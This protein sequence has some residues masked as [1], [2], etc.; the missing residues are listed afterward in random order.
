[1]KNPERFVIRDAWISNE[2]RATLFQRAAVVVLP[3]VSATQSG[4][5]PV[6]YSFRKPVVAT[7]VGALPEYVDHGRT[8]LLVPPCDEKTLAAAVVRL[9]R[10]PDLR[11]SMGENG[12]RTL[13]EKCAP[14]VVAR[15]TV[16]VYRKAIA[17]RK[18]VQGPSFEVDNERRD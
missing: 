12:K 5:I 16:E 18:S 6:A 3:Y 9:L 4:V 8:G 15:S 14:D 7:T 2:E 13:F 1:M 11:H 10:D 17:G